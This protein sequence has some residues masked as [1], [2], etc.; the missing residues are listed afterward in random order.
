MMESWKAWKGKPAGLD[1]KLESWKARKLESWKAGKLE[2]WKAR[3]PE[4]QKAGKLESLWK[5]G[6]PA[7][8]F[9]CLAHDS[10]GLLK[11]KRNYRQDSIIL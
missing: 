5:A 2:S 10:I 8:C 3:K 9:F 4:S 11:K 7:R 1:G 6:K